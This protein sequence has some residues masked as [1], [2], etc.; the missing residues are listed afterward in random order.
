[1]LNVIQTTPLSSCG[2]RAGIA[3]S[4]IQPLED[5]GDLPF[6][7]VGKHR[8]TRLNNV[9][10]LKTKIGAQQT[11]METLAEDAEGPP[12]ALWRLSPLS[13]SLTPAPFIPFISGTFSSRLRWTAWPKRAGRMK[14]HDEWIR[15]Q[16]AR[17]RAVPIERLQ[18]T[19]R[20]MNDALPTAI[21]SGYQEYIKR[22]VSRD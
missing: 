20:L 18:N 22:I 1:V 17:A 12:A 7:Y 16:T 8:R 3:I 2:R 15:N 14:I 6:R 4:G 10:A 5:I 21:V 19:R 9:L 13:R 11:A